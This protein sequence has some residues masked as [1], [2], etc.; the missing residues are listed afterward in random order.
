[1]G[2]DRW[3]FKKSQDLIHI[4]KVDL[5]IQAFPSIRGWRESTSEFCLKKEL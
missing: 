5:A 4:G 3:D 1:M 2:I